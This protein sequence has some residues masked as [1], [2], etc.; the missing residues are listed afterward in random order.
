MDTTVYVQQALENVIQGG[1]ETVDAH[2]LGGWRIFGKLGFGYTTERDAYEGVLNTYVCLPA[3]PAT[4]TATT[5]T[6]SYEPREFIL[7]V[8]SNGTSS[9]PPDGGFDARQQAA[10]DAIVKYVMEQG[11]T[12]NK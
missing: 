4:T 1:I 6:A 11:R 5:T 8:R 9:A 7:S 3:G 10:V 2:T 12:L